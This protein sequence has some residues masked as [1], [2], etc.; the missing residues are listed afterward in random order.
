MATGLSTRMLTEAFTCSNDLESYLK[1]FELLAELLTWKGTE[2]DPARQNDERP[3]FVAL[4]LNKSA[5][6]F[7]RTLPQ[8]TNESYNECVKAF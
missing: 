7:Y 3:H 2:G 8:D 6:H 4:R 1:H 5:I